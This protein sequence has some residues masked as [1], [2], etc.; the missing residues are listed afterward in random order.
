VQPAA[1]PYL[2]VSPAGLTLNTGTN[3]TATLTPM[4]SS[5]ITG[6]LFNFTSSNPLVATVDSFGTVTAVNQGVATIGVIAP[7][8]PCEAEVTVIVN[9]PQTLWWDAESDPVGFDTKY[10]RPRRYLHARPL[11][12]DGW[13]ERY[14]GSVHRDAIASDSGIFVGTLTLGSGTLTVTTPSITCIITNPDGSTTSITAPGS[15]ETSTIPGGS[16]TEVGTS[17]GQAITIPL[18]GF[19][20][21]SG[22]I[23]VLPSTVELTLDW[24]YTVT[25]ADTTVQIQTSGNFTKQ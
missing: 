23:S 5:G 22:V 12:G 7:G 25:E 11:H 13:R 9:P 4:L 15:T 18:P 20:P 24:S 2:T 17:D 21:M 16:G 19:P 3:Q 6:G 1:C 14:P 10:I 8:V